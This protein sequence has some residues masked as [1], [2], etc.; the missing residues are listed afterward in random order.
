MRL[1]YNKPARAWTEALPIGNGRLGAMIFGDA[2]KELLQLN[3][4]T[5]WSGFPRN[6]NNPEAKEILPAL[7]DLLREG[8]FLE[9][10]RISRSML[11]SYS[12]SYL[13]FGNLQLQFEH[14]KIDGNYTR[15]LNLQN[16]DV[17][18]EYRIGNV[19]YKRQIFA[20]H[21][22]QAIVI[23]LTASQP[24]M[25]NLHASLSSPLRSAFSEP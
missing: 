19:H 12:Q 22:D 14:G 6:G 13:P 8:E 16:G 18:I 3:E 17:Q 15:S 5:L 4:D 24:G 7:R 20:S 2:E 21:P 9:A 23:R 25:L 1:Y 11:G 10:D